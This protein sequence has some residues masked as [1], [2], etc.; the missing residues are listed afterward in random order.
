MWNVFNDGLI[1]LMFLNGFWTAGRDVVYYYYKKKSFSA[2]IYTTYSFVT[3]PPRK[4]NDMVS[5]P[6]FSYRVRRSP[7]NFQESSDFQGREGTVQNS[8]PNGHT[9]NVRSKLRV[10]P[11][12]RAVARCSRMPFATSWGCRRRMGVASVVTETARARPL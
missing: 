7:N 6:I 5:L 11:R 10:A 1:L 12:R 4:S 9:C 8:R 3:S 2:Q